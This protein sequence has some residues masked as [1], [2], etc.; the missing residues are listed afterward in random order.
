MMTLADMHK[1]GGFWFLAS[2]YSHHSPDVM[3]SRAWE[4]NDYA[5]RL[6]QQGIICYATIWA[7]HH[8]AKRQQL[9][10]DHEYWLAFNKLWLDLSVGTVVACIPGWGDSAG[11]KQE[12]TYTRQQGKPVY[13]AVNDPAGLRIY[14]AN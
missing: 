6:L 13:M 10:K 3:E 11:V 8:L 9:P 5:G 7:N 12:V 1:L 14:V 2:P 4:V